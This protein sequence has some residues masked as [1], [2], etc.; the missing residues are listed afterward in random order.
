MCVGPGCIHC[1]T[2][3]TRCHE[4]PLVLGLRSEVGDTSRLHDQVGNGFG[5]VH[6]VVGFTEGAHIVGVWA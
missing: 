1:R 5:D 2:G 4:H 6:A 3:A